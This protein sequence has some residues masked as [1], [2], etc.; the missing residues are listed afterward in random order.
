MLYHILAG[1][2]ALTET[3]DRLAR[4]NV[5]RFQEIVPLHEREPDVPSVANQIVQRAMEFNPDKRIQSAAAL[6]AELKKAIQIFESGGS[7]QREADF[8]SPMEDHHDDDEIPTNEGEGYI[9]MLVESK[10]GL[11]NAI[12]ERLKSRG[13]RVLVISDPNRA[14]ARFEPMEDPPADCVIFSASQLGSL[15]MEAFNRFGTDEHTKEIPA[16]LLADKR[17]TELIS[18]APHGDHRKLVSLPLKVR[19][20]RAALLQLLGGV[21]R[22]PPGTY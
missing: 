13:Y 1:T 5:S 22:R 18:Q 11:Q 16:M 10:P 15:A 4:L 3:R 20:L 8:A 14:L 9:V 6:Q 2:P 19:E 12:R 7:N 21:E 17:Q